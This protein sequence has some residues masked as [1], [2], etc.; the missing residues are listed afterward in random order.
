MSDPDHTSGLSDSG[1]RKFLALWSQSER[2]LAFVAFLFIS[3]IT[4]YDVFAREVLARVFFALGLPANTMVIQGGAKMG[5]YALILGAFI[6]LGVAT[7]SGAQIVPKVAFRWLPSRWDYRV[8]QLADVFSGLFFLGAAAIALD[9]VLSSR[10][11]GMISNAGSLRVPVWMFQ[12]VMPLA[13][14]SVAVRYLV[15]AIWPSCRPEL[16]EISE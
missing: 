16:P 12:A 1:P 8:N 2:A 7:Q 14:V 6:G 4:V 3:F 9:F 10:Q 13:F 5:V 15:Y 11:S